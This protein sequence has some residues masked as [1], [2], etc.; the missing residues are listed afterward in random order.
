MNTYTDCKPLDSN[1]FEDVKDAVAGELNIF[2]FL[3]KTFTWNMSLDRMI[4]RKKWIFSIKLKIVYFSSATAT[5]MSCKM[6]RPEI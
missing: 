2:L 5:T 1:F 4:S 6:N 3:K